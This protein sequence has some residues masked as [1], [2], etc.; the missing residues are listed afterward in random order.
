MKQQGYLLFLLTMLLTIGCSAAVDEAADDSNAVMENV[1][2]DCVANYDDAT[3]YFPNKATITHADGFTVEYHNHY[4][5]VTVGAPYNGAEEAVTYVLLQCGTPAPEGM[6]DATIIEVPIKSIVTMSTTY[7]PALEILDELDALVGVDTAAYVTS[8][9]VLQMMAD[10][11]LVE[12]SSGAEVNTESAVD[13]SPDLIMTYASGSPDYDSHPRLQEVGLNVAL[14]AE[15]L[16]STALGRAEW[17]DF[18]ATFFNKEAIAEAWFADVVAEY[19]ELVA[20]TSTIEERPTVF[21][22]TPYEGTW[23]MPGGK[24][25]V[26]QFMTDA[27]ASYLWSDD[28]S[29]GSLYLD[30]ETVFDKAATADYWINVGFFSEL[31]DMAAADERFAEFAAY[32]TPDRV[33]NNDAATNEAGGNDY[34]ES[35]VIYP[36][37]I[38]ADLIKAFHPELLPDHEQVYYRPVQ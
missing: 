13:L 31:T 16:D 35:G 3:D 4:K 15:Y 18:I 8:P 1:T 36:N 22:N 38:L 34:Y 24:S 14:N 9:A 21:A 28:E 26:A 2:T 23:Y 12:I 25:H 33:F 17:V 29:V 5:V 20:L 11:K 37:I 7:L 32:T 30:F 27:G 10:G 19:D 6:D